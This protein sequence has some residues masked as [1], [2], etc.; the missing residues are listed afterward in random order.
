MLRLIIDWFRRRRRNRQRQLFSFFDGRRTRRID[1]MR[2]YRDLDMHPRFTWDMGEL[3]EASD[4]E[5]TIIVADA[6]A[7]VFG[8]TK[9]D[10]STGSGLTTAELLAILWEYCAYNED[11]KKK[12]NDGLILPPATESKPSNAEEV[13]AGATKSCMGCTST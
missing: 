4:P 9:W 3:V 2:V 5:A 12:S 7:D 13:Q 10:P 1:P 6:T 8:L 11:L